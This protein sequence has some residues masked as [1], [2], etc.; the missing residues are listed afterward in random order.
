MANEISVTTGIQVANGSSRRP[1]NQLSKNFDQSAVGI[2]ESTIDVTTSDQSVTLPLSTP[3]WIQLRNDGSNP[4]QWG[5]NNGGAILVMGEISP[6][7]THQIEVP[8]TAST[9]RVKTTTGTSSLSLVVIR[10]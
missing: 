8:S 7:A 10:R 3:G 5:P 6:G 4:I 1:S 2:A 9:I